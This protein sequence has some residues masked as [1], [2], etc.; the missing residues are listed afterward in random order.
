MSLDVPMGLQGA[1]KHLLKKGALTP[2]VDSGFVQQRWVRNRLF[3]YPEG[4]PPNGPSP[5]DG[6][7]R[8]NLSWF[9]QPRRGGEW[10]LR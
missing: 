2:K 9:F 8:K 7:S 5:I 4:L 10:D 6:P 3:D 1:P